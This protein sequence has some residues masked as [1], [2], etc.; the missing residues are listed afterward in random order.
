MDKE[1]GGLRLY[2]I[3][4][5]LEVTAGDDSEALE[6]VDE[7]LKTLVRDRTC[8]VSYAEAESAEDVSML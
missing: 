3:T 5:F 2:S 7:V 1:D 6:M 8:D 4:A